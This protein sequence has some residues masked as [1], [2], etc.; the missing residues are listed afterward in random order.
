MLH[1]TIKVFSILVLTFS[2][3]ACFYE[4]PDFPAGKVTGYRP[5]YAT[6]SDTAITFTEARPVHMPGKIYVYGNFLL[7]NEIREG[8]HVFD[9]TNPSTPKPVGFLSLHGN[10]DMAI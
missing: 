3:S 7:V 4:G 10:E 2:L 9:N 1:K 6:A 5:V 8:I